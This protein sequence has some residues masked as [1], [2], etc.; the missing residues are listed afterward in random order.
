MQDEN[1]MQLAACRGAP[2]DFIVEPDE[3]L[4]QQYCDHCPV[5]QKCLKLGQR[6]DSVGLWGGVF[7]GEP[8][9]SA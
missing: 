3:E 8:S 2:E 5:Q 6:F 9:E 7:L 1:W 4:V